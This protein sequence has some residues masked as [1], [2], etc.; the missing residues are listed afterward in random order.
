MTRD[1]NQWPYVGE[2]GMVANFDD[3]NGRWTETIEQAYYDQLECVPPKAM[4]NNAFM[5]GECYSGRSYAVFVEVDGRFFGK[6]CGMLT[7][8]AT[9]Y[10][11]E[12]R[13]Q[14]GM[15]KS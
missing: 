3:N 8:N 2:D 4:R 13:N 6:I 1:I 14:F 15:V 5:V 7:F 10:T 11:E 12:I 9:K